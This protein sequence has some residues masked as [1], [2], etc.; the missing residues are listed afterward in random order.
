VCAADVEKCDPSKL[1]IT[2]RNGEFKAVS[3]IVAREKTDC[4][5]ERNDTEVF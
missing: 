2:V 4:Q 1:V 5:S 3:E